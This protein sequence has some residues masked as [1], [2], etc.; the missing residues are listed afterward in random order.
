MKISRNKAAK[1]WFITTAVAVIVLGVPLVSFLVLPPGAKLLGIVGSRIGWKYVFGERMPSDAEVERD[2][3][4][5]FDDYKKIREMV[6]ED[7]NNIVISVESVYFFKFDN[8]YVDYILQK[9]RKEFDEA[10][11]SPKVNEHQLPYLYPGRLTQKEQM[12]N[13]AWG[14]K[15]L[16]LSVDRYLLYCSLLRKIGLKKFTAAKDGIVFEYATAY[17]PKFKDSRTKFIAY[18]PHG[19]YDHQ[20][21][22]DDTDLGTN[23]KGEFIHSI[24]GDWYIVLKTPGI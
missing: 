15:R 10:S 21:L 17:P 11:K 8:G 12:V 4:K 1:K 23:L 5:H 18:L 19:Y 14:L 9:N 16:D 2:F 22:T 13:I 24:G 20:I 7:K 3:R 6:K